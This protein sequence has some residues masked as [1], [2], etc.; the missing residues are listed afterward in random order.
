L[1]IAIISD[2]HD[3]I[4]NLRKALA[5]MADV[6][7]LVCCGDLCSP[8]MIQEL[9]EGF[10]GPTHIVFGNNDGDRFRIAD[11]ARAYANIH[12]HG[13]FVEL[14]LAGR[15]IAVN[16][17]DNMGRAM[18]PSREYDVV[19]FGH[20]HRLEIKRLGGTLAINPG[21]IYGLLTGAAT[22]VIY[23]TATHEAARIDIAQAPASTEG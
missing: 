18:S 23:D 12:I 19:C 5:K 1:R 14:E 10:R 2:I 17:F 11:S 6:D 13:E 9:G 16:H 21:E 7:V 8:F 22:F 4:P 15:K 20:N 3:N